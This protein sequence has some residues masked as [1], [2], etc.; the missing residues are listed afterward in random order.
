M[1]Y[2]KRKCGVFR[3]EKIFFLIFKQRL[4]ANIQL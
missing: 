2:A 1:G 4:N 3:F